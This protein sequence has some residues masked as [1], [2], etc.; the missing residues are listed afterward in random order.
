MLVTNGLGALGAFVTACYMKKPAEATY[1]R[2]HYVFR[3]IWHLSIGL[4]ALW[5][6]LKGVGL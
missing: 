1:E 2:G 4:W 5:I 6:L 3:S